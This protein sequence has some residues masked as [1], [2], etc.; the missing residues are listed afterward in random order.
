MRLLLAASLIL[1]PAFTATAHSPNDSGKSE[2]SKKICKVDPE[3]TDSRIRRRICKTEA[4]WNGKSQD[5]K[6]ET[7]RSPKQ[8]Q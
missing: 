1:L 2:A 6:P 7:D 4:E 8:D 5:V 3:D